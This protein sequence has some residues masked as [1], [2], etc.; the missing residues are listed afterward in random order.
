MLAFSADPVMRWFWADSFRY[1]AYWPRFAEA[2]GGRAFDHGTAHWL[3]DGRGVTLWL[4]PGVGPD[5]AALGA[6]MVDTLDGQTL[7]QLGA[8]SEQMARFHPTVD[9]WYLALAGVD[10]FAQGRGLG[11][12]LLRHGLATC[13]REGLPAYLEASSPRNRRLYQRVGFEVVGVVQAGTSP[14]IWAMLREPEARA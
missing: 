2:F 1:A 9:H 6:L 11:S 7:G 10:P 12:T 14:P 13:D 8:M 5:D 4:P 3:D